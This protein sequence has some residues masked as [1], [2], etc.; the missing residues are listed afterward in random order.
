MCLNQCLTFLSSP[1]LYI[2]F[3]F[4][5]VESSYYCNKL[6]KYVSIDILRGLQKSY[7]NRGLIILRLGMHVV[8][9]Y[10]I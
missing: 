3:G 4:K 1:S 5:E 6:Y 10:I 8:S 2:T 9:K 7:P